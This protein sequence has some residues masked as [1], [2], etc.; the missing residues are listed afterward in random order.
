[1][2]ILVVRFSSIGD[3]VL[4]TSI[5]RC[6]KQQLPNSIIHYFTKSAYKDLVIHNP[7]ID[8]VYELS[9]NWTEN[10]E[11]LKKEKYDYVIDLHHNLRTKRLKA[12]L[13][14]PAFSFPKRNIKKFLFTQL[15][16]NLLLKDEHVVDRYFEAVKK[17]G[18]LNDFL[19][20]EIFINDNNKIEFAN[21]GIESKNYLAVSVGAQ[22]ATKKMPIE[23]I[24]QVLN[25]VETPVVLLGD[26]NDQ[27]EAEK[28]IASCRNKKIISFCGSLNLL[29]SAFVMSH[30]KA[31]LCH[32]TG[33]MHIAACFKIPIIT[34][35]GNTTPDFGMYAYTPMN[36]NQAINFE[37]ENLS[38][39]PCS[40]I[41]YQKCPKGHF[42]CMNL[43]NK[44]GIIKEVN[45]RINNQ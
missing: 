11:R 43:Q 22:F 28:I 18:V 19:P 6:L 34:V 23:F 41:G 38:C 16:L 1:M 8:Q 35:W 26:K 33:L 27:K 17:L 24:S 45:K 9:E 2:K 31:A 32:D 20:N 13:K 44:E 37:V 40:K 12:A 7:N 30:A 15:K 5:V 36:K 10:I 29:Q 25:S 14:T 4:T 39:R 42:K 21:Y 3:I